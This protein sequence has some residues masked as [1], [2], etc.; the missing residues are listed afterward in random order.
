M[1]NEN[2]ILEDTLEEVVE[3]E[4]E[5]E[6]EQ[7]EQKEFKNPL[8]KWNKLIYTIATVLFFAF[9]CFSYYAFTSGV[10]VT[11]EAVF[12]PQGLIDYISAFIANI[13]FM[14]GSGLIIMPFIFMMVVVVAFAVLEIIMTIH[15]IAIIISFIK[16]LLSKADAKIKFSR[17]F[18]RAMAFPATTLTII[19]LCLS[20]PDS[21]LTSIGSTL[22]ILSVVAFLFV[23]VGNKT[24]TLFS[25][26]EKDWAEYG[27]SLGRGLVITAIC[28]LFFATF[29]KLGFST[30]MQYV[31]LT[32]TTSESEDIVNVILAMLGSAIELVLVLQ[33]AGVAKKTLKYYPLNNAKRDVNAILKRKAIALIVE[34]VLV[35][36]AMTYVNMNI[37]MALDNKPYLVL[38]FGAIGM[39]F[40]LEVPKSEKEEIVRN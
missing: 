18:K 28:A 9:A 7:P 22:L 13:N 17:I 30:M 3:V 27:I 11:S 16:A 33:A 21:K 31:P 8:E 34:V 5:V 38:L 40:C 39:L 6:T 37:N 24:L 4:T 2:I 25:H 14:A 23:F 20:L 19:A 36:A 32:S 1:N 35:F 15:L 26:E 10:A 29:T 12:S